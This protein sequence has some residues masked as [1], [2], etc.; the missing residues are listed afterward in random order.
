MP[1]LDQEAHGAVVQEPCEQSARGQAKHKICEEKHKTR[2][3][4]ESFELAHVHMD[5]RVWP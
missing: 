3:V 1:C 5:F 2:P 4:L